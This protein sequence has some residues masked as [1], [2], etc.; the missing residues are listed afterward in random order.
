MQ[1]GRTYGIPYNSGLVFPR[2]T[3]PVDWNGREHKNQVRE[4]L[5]RLLVDGQS[6]DEDIAKEEENREEDWHLP[7][8]KNKH[9]RVRTGYYL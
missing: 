1:E 8:E 6:K 4:R 7:V 2:N 3:N 9:Q 5:F